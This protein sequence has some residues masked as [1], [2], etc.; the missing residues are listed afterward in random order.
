MNSPTIDADVEAAPPPQGGRDRAPLRV[1]AVVTVVGLVVAAVGAV[2]GFWPLSTPT[3]DCGTAAS[4]MIQ[5]RVNVFVNP[6][7]PPEGIT[8]DEARANNAE[9]C[10]ERAANRGLIALALVV[11][12]AL[13]GVVSVITEATIRLRSRLRWRRLHRTSP[14]VAVFSDPAAPPRPDPTSAPSTDPERH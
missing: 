12:G 10:Q 8:P 3:Q 5:G 13:A 2:I 4:F 7:N 11:G 6:D 1:P 14:P 9:P